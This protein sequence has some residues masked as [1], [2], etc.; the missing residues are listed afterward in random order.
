MATLLG[1]VL[2]YA[3]PPKRVSAYGDFPTQVSACAAAPRHVPA[4]TAALA[5]TSG[6]ADMPKQSSAYAAS[7]FRQSCGLAIDDSYAA[8]PGLQEGN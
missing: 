2:A 7:K 3:V 8:V 5:H 6:C 1:Q 4:H